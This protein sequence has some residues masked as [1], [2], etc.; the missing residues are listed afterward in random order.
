ML[1][2]GIVRRAED[3]HLDLVEPVDAKMPRVSLPCD[4]ASRR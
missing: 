4:P 1:R 3:E 2:I